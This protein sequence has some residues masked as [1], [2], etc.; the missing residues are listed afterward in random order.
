MIELYTSS[1]PNGYKASVTLE[2][3]GLP[4]TV[5]SVALREQE[6]KKPEFLAL[7]PNG[8]IPVII[9]RD[10]DDLVIFES[11]AIMVYLAEKTGQLMPQDPAGKA[12][13]MQWLM[14][15][16]SGIG[17]IMGNANVFYRYFPEKIP[18][19]ID[20]FQNE[21]RRLFE[22]LDSRLA[23]SEWLADDYSI[24]DIANWCWVRT[25]KWSGIS[26][27]G[28]PHLKRWRD[29]IRERPAAQR[30][31]AQP[32]AVPNIVED[33]SATRAFSEGARSNVQ[34]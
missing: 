23:Q 22:V 4:Y 12:Q 16:M 2:E 1:T 32:A 24:A 8:R 11:G 25:Y 34:R 21:S 28:L 20:R 17:P 18:A 31:I 3:L 7:N 13:V 15:Q 14:F 30:G 10:A 29:A 26:V 33:E 6:Q 27:D 19:A 5:H 9:D